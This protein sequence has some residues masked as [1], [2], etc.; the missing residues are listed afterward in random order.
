MC[1][2]CLMRA[3]QH[4]KFIAGANRGHMTLR[5]GRKDVQRSVTTSCRVLL[6]VAYAAAASPLTKHRKLVLT[7]CAADSAPRTS[8]HHYRFIHITTAR[9]DVQ[10][11]GAGNTA[12]AAARRARAPH[13]RTTTRLRQREQRSAAAPLM[14]AR[15]QR[16]TAARATCSAAARRAQRAQPPAAPVPRSPTQKCT[17]CATHSPL[18][19][20]QARLRAFMTSYQRAATCGAAA[21]RL[22]CAQQP[23]APARCPPAQ[24]RIRCAAH[25]TPPLRRS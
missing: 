9:R 16:L 17:R 22:R 14:P 13:A 6:C 8:A 25:S 7:L 20:R 19:H 5:W 2:C 15:V 18:R 10:H 3:Y 1:V 11:G 21:R 23:T 12:R 4:T 24:Q